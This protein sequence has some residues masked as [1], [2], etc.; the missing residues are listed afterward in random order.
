MKAV[1]FIKKGI[2]KVC[3]KT[4]DFIVASVGYYALLAKKNKN[5]SIFLTSC[6]IGDTVYGLAYIEEYKRN[7]SDR[8]TVVI[9]EKSKKQIVNS[10]RGIDD[11][12]YYDKNSACGRCYL[13]KLNASK[14]YAHKLAKHNIYNIIPWVKY[15]YHEDGGDCLQLL[16]D[17]MGLQDNANPVCFS[18]SD[19]DDAI[20]NIDGFETVRNHTVVVNPYTGNKDFSEC[21]QFLEQAV[22]HLNEIGFVVYCNA[23]KGQSVI[24][25]AR[26]LDCSIRELY[27]ICDKI[28]LVISIRSGIMDYLVGTNSNKIIVYPENRTQAFKDMYTMAAWKKDN[29]WEISIGENREFSDGDMELIDSLIRP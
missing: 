27:S 4:S 19:S 22:E 11:V 8:K 29:I 25:G 6:A 10:Y 15:G 21:R 26:R 5:D 2:G 18:P 16:R 28:P 12:L 1:E 13:L 20:S 3:K 9:A 14:Y 17:I 23:I 24:E 7:H